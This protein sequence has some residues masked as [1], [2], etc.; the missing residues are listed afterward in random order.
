M[1]G[2][3]KCPRCNT[4]G[5]TKFLWIVKCPNSRCRHYDSAV[6]AVASKKSKT[7]TGSFS[8]GANTIQVSYQNHAG[9]HRTYI[10]DRTTIRKRRNHLTIVLAPAGRRCSFEISRISNMAT[11]AP[12]LPPE[13]SLNLTAVDRQVIGYHQ[14]HGST[15]PRLEEIKSKLTKGG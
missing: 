14:R 8:P 4:P 9:E 13:S 10:G 7:P 5:A 12:F 3:I 15:S 1:A 6:A 11:L 2:T